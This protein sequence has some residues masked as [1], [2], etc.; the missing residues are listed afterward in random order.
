MPPHD[1]PNFITHKQSP[2]LRVLWVRHVLYLI[3]FFGGKPPNALGSL[4]E[5]LTVCVVV[6]AV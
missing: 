4:R 1:P 5:S 3:R 6:E 2:L